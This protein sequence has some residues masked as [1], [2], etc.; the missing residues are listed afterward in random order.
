MSLIKPLALASLALLALAGCAT[1]GE[2]TPFEKTGEFI[3]T[4][5]SSASFSD[6]RVVSTNGN[7]SKRSDGSW[8]GMLDGQLYNLKVTE[9]RIRGTNFN[10]TWE[11]VDR[12]FRG[13]GII[14]GQMI[15]VD[16]TASQL[17]VRAFNKTIS[18]PRTSESTFGSGPSSVIL[19]G[20]ALQLPMPQSVL[21]LLAM[22]RG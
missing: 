3:Y 20:E 11:N 4:R 18:L 8:A 5:G 17:V 15:K 16:V 9:N 7:F 1:T 21:A 22:A 19:E 14:Q 12:G 13:Q 6:D 2:S 10:F